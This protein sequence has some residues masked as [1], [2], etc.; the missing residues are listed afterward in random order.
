[1]GD[2][3]LERMGIIGGAKDSGVLAAGRLD[4]PVM[5]LRAGWDMM[6]APSSLTDLV[7]LCALLTE[8]MKTV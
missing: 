4:R 8:I 1:M 2:E 5:C 6:D 3:P 7:E